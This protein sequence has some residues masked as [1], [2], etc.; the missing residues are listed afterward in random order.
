MISI[1]ATCPPRAPRVACLDLRGDQAPR[2]E[3]GPLAVVCGLPVL[4]RSLLVLERAGYQQA[5]LLV[6]SEYRARV[7]AELARHPRLRMPVAIVDVDNKM[8]ADSLAPLMSALADAPAETQVLFWPATLSFGRR[9]PELGELPAGGILLGT[10][11]ESGRDSGL[12][13]VGAAVLRMRSALS[14]SALAAEGQVT[15]APMSP[16]PVA[17]RDSAG[18]RQAERALL[19]SLRKDADGVVAKF[20]RYVSLAISRWLMALPIKP[21]H[22][23][24]FAALV[25]VSCG[26]IVAHGGYAWMLCG[27]LAFQFNSILDGVDGEIARAKLLESRTGQWMDTLSDDASNLSFILGVSVGS[28]RTSGSGVYLGLGA[29]AGFGFLMAS[30][31]MYHYLITQAH[32]GDLNDFVM[33]WK[34]GVRERADSSGRTMNP[35]SRALARMQWMFRRDTYAFLCTLCGLVGQLR[36]MVWLFALGTTL[37]WGSILGYRALVSLCSGQGSRK[38]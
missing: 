1:S 16:A 4:V 29:M 20:D 19:F 37:A 8:D 36:I 2:S 3:G 23:T 34:Q 32:S 22:V 7:R 26:L 14:W 18:A 24:L 15:R 38:A 10:D 30:A 28:Y 31:L 25:G 21:N 17:V 27:A 35:V 13:V 6:P 11:P 33:P 5:F 9:M 12:A